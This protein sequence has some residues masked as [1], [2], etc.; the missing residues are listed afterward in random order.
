MN[1]GDQQDYS[2][3][4]L[5]D[6]PGGRERIKVD[7]DLAGPAGKWVVVFGVGFSTV[8]PAILSRS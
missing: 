3:V 5:L 7:V 1:A 8:N 6:I 4:G 2:S